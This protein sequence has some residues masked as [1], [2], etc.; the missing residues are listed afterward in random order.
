MTDEKVHGSQLTV[1]RWRA[2]PYRERLDWARR[3]PWTM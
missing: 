1:H 2:G 3:S